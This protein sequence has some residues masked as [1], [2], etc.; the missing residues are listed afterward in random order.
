MRLLMV[1]LVIPLILNA[2]IDKEALND[3]IIRG[4]V[5]SIIQIYSNASNDEKEYIVMK[6]MQERGKFAVGQFQ[7][8]MQYMRN[9]A[10]DMELVL[11]HC[12]N[13]DMDER[14]YPYLIEYFEML[15]PDKLEEFI[16]RYQDSGLDYKKY[17]ILYYKKGV[18]GRLTRQSKKGSQMRFIFSA[19]MYALTDSSVYLNM[20]NEYKGDSIAVLVKDGLFNS[21]QTEAIIKGKKSELGALIDNLVNLA[22]RNPVEDY[23][24]QFR[25]TELEEL[26]ADF[27]NGRVPEI[28]RDEKN[29]NIVYLAMAAAL[30][31]GDNEYYQDMHTE[32][33][34][35]DNTMNYL[36]CL[37]Y[38]F[39]SDMESFRTLLANVLVR[40]K[41][42]SAGIR[43]VELLTLSAYSED[44]TLYRML[45]MEQYQQMRPILYLTAKDTPLYYYYLLKTG[46]DTEG[47]KEILM[48]GAKTALHVCIID[49]A[50]QLTDREFLKEFIRKYPESP[51]N[52]FL[53]RII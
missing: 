22:V 5:G 24:E 28:S 46:A 15:Y 49:Y 33:M 36:D 13:A 3:Y 20:L 4:S 34:N 43:L 25:G 44:G 19:R 53:R 6:V 31:S 11:K 26:Y 21:S 52:I 8:F 1:L 48:S 7:I 51:I 41:S 27:R 9:N 38:L 12:D 40:E 42:E 32:A 47:L 16:L 17:S 10:A 35:S 14:I 30:Y 2:S 45:I 39:T 18:L 23:T 29:R 50:E 37:Y